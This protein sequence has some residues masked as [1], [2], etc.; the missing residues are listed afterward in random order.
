MR[1]GCHAPSCWYILT[2]G[3]LQRPMKSSLPV[4]VTTILALLFAVVLIRTAWLGDDAQISFRTILNFTHGFG[5]TF[6]IAERVQT[7]THPLWLFM[8]TAAYLIV[9]NIYYA[10]FLLSIATS[11]LVFTLVVR[12]A[13]TPFQACLSAGLLVFSRAFVDYSTSG[14]ENPLSNLLL[15]LAVVL[16]LN[17]RLGRLTWLAGLWTLTSLLYLTRPDN[18]LVILPLIALACYQ[19]RRPSRIVAAAAIGLTPAIGWTL[20]SIVYYGFPFPNTAYAKLATGIASTELWRQGL[21]YLIDSIDRDP[22]TLATIG[23]TGV[24]A[25]RAGVLARALVVG[26]ALELLYVVSIGGD[27]MSG[28]FMTLPFV[29][30]VCVLSRMVI[31]TQWEWIAST[32]VLGAITVGSSQ[33]SVLSNSDFTNQDVADSGIADER[34]YFFARLSLSGSD[35]SRFLEPDWPRAVD[36]GQAPSVAVVC[37][38]LGLA[39]LQG[40]YVHV[41][42]VCALADP[43]LARLP[44]IWN[45]QWRVGHFERMVPAGYR[46]SLVSGTNRLSDRTLAEYY[47]RIRFVTRS[48]RLLT[49]ERLR[50]IVN[51]NLGAY[52]NLINARFYH[53]NGEIAAIEQLAS[54]K[55][56]GTPT[57]APGNR[58]V[59]RLLA[60]GCADRPGRRYLDLSVDPAYSY[61]V[62]FVQDNAVL[63]SVDLGAVPEDQRK[64]GLARFTLDVPARAV[65]QGFDTIVIVPQRPD[66]ASALGHVIIEGYPETDAELYQRVETR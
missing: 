26:I 18:V 6:N 55:T 28:R 60:V 62:S 36:P 39:G 16:Y 58:S 43:L 4:R 3:T 63:S 31:A 35:R 34:G 51:L 50:N 56:D 9:G 8:L 20:F 7:Y 13:A 53:Y 37:G 23:L 42:D 5:L 46:D 65:D 48:K 15:V 59:R 22:I 2:M 38:G 19:V 64:P 17:D 45:E 66:G 41:L 25:L 32:A 21:V 61:K 44:S 52:D 57:D 30:S 14:L 11:L 27:F 12:G 33:L 1:V 24:F 47:E 40:P 10:A 54:V 49:I 29:A